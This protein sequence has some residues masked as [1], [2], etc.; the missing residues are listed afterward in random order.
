MPVLIIAG[1]HRSGT[2]LTASLLQSAGL[3]IGERLVPAD[4][5]NQ[6]GHFEDID[7]HEFHRRA[8]HATGHA[9]DGFVKS[10][11][12]D[13]P[14]LLEQEARQLIAARES[15]GRPWGWKDPRTVLFLDHWHRLLP[16]SF[17]LFVFRAPWEVVDSLYR[18]SDEVFGL[19]PK[20]ALDAWYHYNVL[21]KAFVQQYADKS[22]MYELPQVISETTAV[23]TAIRRR[24]GIQLQTPPSLYRAEML[25][26]QADT[27]H[28]SIVEQLAPQ[29]AALYGELQELAGVK[30][31]TKAI[32]KKTATKPEREL[33][34]GVL[35]DW[36]TI[37]HQ[38]RRITK[39]QADES[40][41]RQ[42]LEATQG[43]K[44]ASAESHQAHATQLE[45]RIGELESALVETIQG[46]ERTREEISRSHDARVAH[47]ERLVQEMQA[48]LVETRQNAANEV[49]GTVELHRAHATQ[50]EQRIG[51]LE[52]ALVETTQGAERIR[53]EMSRSHDDRVAYYER[54]IQEIQAELVET[55]QNAAN[56]V[57]ATVEAHRA[58]ATELEQR[59]GELESALVETTQGAE[60]IREEMSRSHDDRVAHYERLIQEIQAELVET[61]RNAANEVR[62]KAESHQA[63]AHD[64]ERLVGDLQV[65]VRE[66]EQQAVATGEQYRAH[67]SE[68][69]K[70]AGDWERK[71]KTQTAQ[72]AELEAKWN[73]LF[74]LHERVIHSNSWRLTRPLRVLRRSTLSKPAAYLQ[75]ALSRA[76]RSVWRRLPG[77]ISTK[78]RLRHFLFTR[79]PI[80]FRWT[81]SYQE[82]ASLY[83]TQ[84]GRSNEAMR[85]LSASPSRE[86]GV[87]ASSALQGPAGVRLIAMH[88][89]Q[90]HRIP[91]NDAWW[92]EGF[93]EWT[94]V[95]RGRSMYQ[96]HYQP[97]VPHADIGYYD[98]ANPAT[99][100]QQ[101]TLAQQYGVHGFCFYYYWFNGRR[102]LEKPLKDMLASGKPD[103]PFCICWANENWTR[104]WDGN[105]REVL[106]AQ[107]HTH[108]SDERF[109][110]DLLPYVRDRRYIRVE[111]KPL[112]AVY[113]A[114]LLP[115]PSAAAAV[116]RKVCREQGIGE[117][118]LVAVRSFDKEDPRRYGFD[119]AIQFPP[120]QIP[121]S[122]MASVGQIRAEPVFKGIVLD[123]DEA[124]RFSLAE[125]SSGYPMYRGV[126]PSWDNTARRME[127]ATSWINS[128]PQKYGEWLRQAVDR[129]VR[130]QP[131]EHRLVFINAWNEWAEGAHLEPDERHG[132]RFLEETQAAVSPGKNLQPKR[133]ASSQATI[134]QEPVELRE[135]AWSQV[136]DIVGKPLSPDVYGFL[137]D[138]VS[139]VKQVSAVGCQFE[140]TGGAIKASLGDK[141]VTIST[142]ADMS[143]LMALA[144]PPSEESPFCF[145]V[146]Q[147]NK[148]EVTAR[149]V[150]TLRRLTSRRPIRILV[151]DNGSSE[152]VQ[153]E[154]RKA[155]AAMADVELLCTGKNLGFAGG[156]NAGYDHARRVM[157]AAFIAVINND[158]RIEQRDFIE[159]CEAL[160]RAWG[161]SV[162][163]PDIVTPDGRRENPWN[164]TVYSPEQWRL[165]ASMYEE[166]YAAFRR[167]GQARFRRVGKRTPEAEF[168][169]EA[170]LQGAAYVLSPMFVRQEPRLFDER[171]SL[172][173]EEF[174]FATECL[175]AGHFTMY[176]ASVQILHDEGVSTSALPDATKMRLGYENAKWAATC[177]AAAI[178]N[179]VAIWRGRPVGPRTAELD[180]LLK[181]PKRHILI[182]LFFCQ[183]GYHGGGEYGKAVFK[184]IA[185]SAACQSGVQVWAALD[186]DL[187]ID[188]WV[189][190]HCRVQGVR[191][192]AVRAYEDI[193]GLV[194]SDRFAAFFCPAIVVYTGYEY[195]RRAGSGLP[196]T[197]KRT[198]I[199][200]ALL[201]IRD[202]QLA[203]D[204][205]RIT[206]ALSR[207]GWGA[208]GLETASNSFLDPRAPSAA[209]LREMYGAIVTDSALETIVT[210][211]EYCRDSIVRECG[212][213]AA[214][215][216]VL[217]AAEKDRVQPEPFDAGNGPALPRLFAL[218]L[219]AGRPEKN[220]A[221]VVAAFDS[222]FSSADGFGLGDLKVILTGINSLD[223]LGVRHVLNQDRFMT[224][225]HVQ[226]RHLEYLLAQAQFLVYASFNEG[227]GYPPVEAMRYG[228]PSVVSGTTAI[229]EVCGDAVVYCDPYNADSIAAAILQISHDPPA[230]EAI[231]KQHMTVQQRQKNDLETLVKVV[232]GNTC[233]VSV[234]YQVKENASV[235]ETHPRTSPSLPNGYVKH[236]A[237]WCAICEKRVIFSAESDWLRDSYVCDK[238]HSLPRERAL[239]YVLHTRRP[240]WRKLRIHESSPENR[241]VSA[242]LRA[243]CE[244][245]TPSQ[246]DPAT[247]SGTWEAMR[248]YRSEDLEHQSFP[249]EHFDIVITQDVFEH[250]FDV[251][252]AFQEI[253][254]TLRPGGVHILTTPLVRAGSVSRPRAV[255]DEVG[256]R[257][258]L[259]AE[260]HGNPMSPA[261][262]LVTW[263]WG[264]DLEEL[265]HDWT[266]DNVERIAIEIPVMGIVAEL[267]DVIVVTRLTER[268]AQRGK[269]GHDARSG[270][271]RNGFINVVDAFGAH[272]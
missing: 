218:V 214:K 65:S 20:L 232:L 228:T 178:D 167:T 261:G 199:I 231:A 175:L 91:E 193:V 222:V 79:V 188:P 170:L 81:I 179:G 263:D 13:L 61:R 17:N 104:T 146:L 265:I 126:M 135:R 149:C 49:R 210:I 163:G 82:W 76:G 45:Q 118:H 55:R 220:A 270:F 230:R 264:Y 251:R 162:L 247:P 153:H 186:P 110:Y 69:E 35:A 121:A 4:H 63:H 88:L 240:N 85:G 101:A 136:Q 248:Q 119:A 51:E 115:D 237:G 127:R 187:F 112:I 160:Y 137:C 257:H 34:A 192:I 109:I 75:S 122:D 40:H 155:I 141:I 96:G 67:V 151:V 145:V 159:R 70:W 150:E 250:I 26:R 83:G 57:R 86:R 202:L 183:P 173:G 5:G 37:R 158:T 11:Q 62:A 165:L 21:V 12:I 102:V 25:G 31:R 253:Q 28:I 117:I 142:R 241:G 133:Q 143:R 194:N 180:D 221:S 64:L 234:A 267:L 53:E 207:A 39:L 184:A 94:N 124:A 72:I 195:M 16:H 245:Y 177:S 268:C 29:C 258:L 208:L 172:Y 174:V 182:D 3:F 78:Y 164:D 74:A 256:I 215:L 130:E 60:R 148:W 129:T 2:S 236:H 47:C 271:I 226:P 259:P 68:L 111:G 223:E 201:D 100:E 246:F 103:F 242:K 41:L 176:S 200:G 19:N 216:V 24:C 244:Q 260:Y 120:L 125:E 269:L 254:R 6:A 90:F 73:S 50:L 99:L 171:T 8:L 217:T 140:T 229:P 27:H 138:Y 266:G 139:I 196:F 152:D 52:S 185:S 23:I 212:E 190:E 43:A 95:R 239:M 14:K 209:Q 161:Y 157:G 105:D 107:Q 227:F 233:T 56:E 1:M 243:E 116:W 272:N 89:P 42:E 197:C 36:A 106:L 262:S 44:L 97:H 211:S 48:E 7:F 46:A 59:I 15:L 113:R 252:K 255:R 134:P 66:K 71:S 169:P 114:G 204:R 235:V 38:Q 206:D 213:P 249:S 30:P 189:L 203:E 98:L 32:G 108:E 22:L 156:N 123:Y 128:S 191:I 225:P 132:Y 147:Y 77:A 181:A 54:L 10:A 33:C 154:T 166:D 238:C 80:L 84:P 144:G 205:D 87:V 9:E 198:R 93:T 92:G 18:R 131:E 168:L 58:H 224:L 219:N